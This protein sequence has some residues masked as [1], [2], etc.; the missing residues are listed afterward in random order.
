MLNQYWTLKYSKIKPATIT[1][2]TQFRIVDRKKKNVNT[3]AEKK[4]ESQ[5][6]ILKVKNI[7]GTQLT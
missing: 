2:V 4:A 3:K 5:V 6:E 1:F 7:T